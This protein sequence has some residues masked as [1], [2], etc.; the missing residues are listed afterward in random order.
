MSLGL[1]VLVG[2]QHYT[3]HDDDT[4]GTVEAPPITSEAVAA[5]TPGHPPPDFSALSL[6]ERPRAEFSIQVGDL[7]SPYRVLGTLVLPGEVLEI[8]PVLGPVNASYS[9]D[10][11]AGRVEADSLSGGWRYTAPTT[12][13]VHRVT[14]AGPGEAVR[15][16]V[17]VQTPYDP[18]DKAIGG[19]RIGTYKSRALRNNPRFERPEGFLALTDD[20]RGTRV[21][22]HFTIEQF[23]CKQPGS[24]RYLTLDER[25]VLKLE[26]ILEEVADR[27]INAETFTVMSA[28]RTPWY[29]ASIGNRTSYSL[30]LYGR[31]ADIYVDDDGDG[32][33]DD[34][35]G[36]GQV[37][38]ADARLLYNVVNSLQSEAWYQPFI[39]GLGL[40]GPK[41][42]RGPFIH[43]D[44][45]GNPARW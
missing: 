2:M 28:Y 40:Y 44:V 21:S 7:V 5:T 1:L 32:R 38:T 11:E 9:I 14:I 18:A 41:P 20:V 36:D 31:A 13:G 15:L 8:E 30:H 43:V 39:G 19:Y 16:N 35:T 25:L 10:A 37:T 24:P 42:H 17:F 12:P 45:R 27:G 6:D 3:A 29:N 33:M 26:M 34:L 4:S 22:P 23:A